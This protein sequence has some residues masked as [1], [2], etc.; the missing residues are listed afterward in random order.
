MK[1]FREMFQ[2]LPLLNVAYSRDFIPPHLRLLKFKFFLE[3][4]FLKEF[5]SPLQNIIAPVKIA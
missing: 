3:I 2:S 5:F 1:S 4:L